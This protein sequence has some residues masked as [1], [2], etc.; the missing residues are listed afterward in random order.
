MSDDAKSTELPT[1]EDALRK[2]YIGNVP[3]ETPRTQPTTA[4]GEP[5]VVE[6][7][8]PTQSEPTTG[9]DETEAARFGVRKTSK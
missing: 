8:P 6:G 1:F 4:T 7:Q 2:G 3:A 5:A 9:T